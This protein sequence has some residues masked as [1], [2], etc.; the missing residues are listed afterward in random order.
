M[1]N[2]NKTEIVIILDRSGSMGSIAGDVR[3]SYDTYIKEQ[4]KQVGECTITLVQFDHEY[5]VVYQNKRIEEVS[6]LE[7]VPRGMTALY[8]AIGKAIKDTGDKLSTLKEED[9]PGKVLVVIITDGFENT[10]VEYKVGDISEM[11]KHQT[12][13]Y[14]WN[15]VFLA[16]NQDAIMTGSKM[17][18]IHGNC[19]S[20]ATNSSAYGN[21]ST[22]LSN[23]TSTIRGGGAAT[24]S[25]EDRNG[26]MV[27]T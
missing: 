13:K 6:G 27:N 1:N 5:E 24:F 2:N 20:F 18:I 4:R 8:D 16:A 22:S 17:G 10:S 11:I 7:F 21:A 3:G 14:N 19:L 15:F 12:E 26:A 9:R 25:N 23:Y